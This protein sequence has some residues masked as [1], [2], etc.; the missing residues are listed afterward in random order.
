MIKLNGQEKKGIT[1][2][3]QTSHW[4]KDIFAVSKIEK[5]HG[6][7][8]FIE[9]YNVYV[10]F[11]KIDFKDTLFKEHLCNNII[12]HYIIVTCCSVSQNVMNVKLKYY[13][14]KRIQ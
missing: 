1:E 9:P 10:L 6:I 5:K 2:K 12:F 13:D 8:L 7:N 3:Q 4:L 11:N 14:I